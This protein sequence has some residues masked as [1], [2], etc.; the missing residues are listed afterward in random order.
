MALTPVPGIVWDRLESS[1]VLSHVCMYVCIYIYT[2]YVHI[3]SKLHWN[4]DHVVY[5]QMFA[6]HEQCNR[7][8]YVRSW[9]QH[10]S[11]PLLQCVS[12]CEFI[13]NDPI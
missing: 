7:G 5:L 10:L 11:V 3:W 8:H 1:N 6:S 13:I 2:L 12:I 4:C 9:F